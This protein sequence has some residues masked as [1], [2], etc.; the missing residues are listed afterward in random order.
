MRPV[1]SCALVFAAMAALLCASADAQRTTSRKERPTADRIPV[2]AA[3]ARV[4]AHLQFI[5]ARANAMA[6]TYYYSAGAERLRSA[7]SDAGIGDSMPLADSWGKMGLGLTWSQAAKEFYTYH[8]DALE[9]SL[10]II[11][12][13][14]YAKKSD[15]AYIDDGMQRWKEFEAKL[16]PLFEELVGYYVRD[17]Q[18]HDESDAYGK[19]Y[20]AQLD[21]LSPMR[22]YPGGQINALNGEM[23]AKSRE[24]EARIAMAEAAEGMMQKMIQERAGIRVFSSIKEGLVTTTID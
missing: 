22:P 14:G 19:Q 3:R 17:A 15:M 7:F 12:L 1:R 20:Q 5:E 16:P 18:I 2:A 23:R 10:R 24:F 9:E 13:Q 21:R 4:R 6:N 8:R 11:E